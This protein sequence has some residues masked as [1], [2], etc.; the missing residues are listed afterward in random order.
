MPVVS[1]R[2]SLVSA[3]LAPAFMRSAPPTVPG[4]P[5][6][7]SSPPIPAD[8][9]ISAT[10]LSSAAGAALTLSPP[11]LASPKPRGPSLITTP[12]MPPSRTIRLE[13]TPTTYTASSPGKALKKYPRSSASAGVNSTCAGPPTRN[14]VNSASDWFASSRPR[15]SGITALRSGAMSGKVM[16]TFRS[17][18]PCGGGLGGGGGGGGG[19][20]A[21]SA[22]LAATPHPNPPPQGGREQ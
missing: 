12:G 13:P 8:A 9:A 10:R 6:K 17:L 19:G 2:T 18:P 21:T 22:G 4:M 16:W 11:A 15:N 1:I 20:G 7:N 14:Q 3:P 5:N